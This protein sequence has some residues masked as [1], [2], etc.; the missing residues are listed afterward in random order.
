MCPAVTQE[1]LHKP[2]GDSEA[3]V[4]DAKHPSHSTVPG[5]H[6]CWG[7]PSR[8][9]KQC[10]SLD[11]QHLFFGRPSDG[12]VG[13]IVLLCISRAPLVLVLGVTQSGGIEYPRDVVKHVT[14]HHLDLPSRTFL[15]KP[16]M[17]SFAVNVMILVTGR[18]K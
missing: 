13:P 3:K 12:T 7:V 5:T 2:E 18:Y 17:R 4:P 16:I 10:E 6:K 8:I 15:Y 9:A 14:H 1:P 11:S